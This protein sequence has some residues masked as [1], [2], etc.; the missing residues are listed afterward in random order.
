[1]S[2][3]SGFT[4]IELI[5]VILLLGAASVLFFVQKNGI[6]VAARDEQRKTAINA[7]HYGLEE[8]YYKEH[9]TY[10]RLLDETVLPFVDPEL[11]TDPRGVKVSQS[12]V[13]IDDTE[14]PVNPEY[15]YE[16]KNCSDDACQGYSLRA[17]LENE[18]DFVKTNQN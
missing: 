16:G 13:I 15:R 6:E 12:V 10:P 14:Y 18:D 2:R 7:M 8:I 4:V 1:M 3:H 17:T 9:G 5:F 11:F